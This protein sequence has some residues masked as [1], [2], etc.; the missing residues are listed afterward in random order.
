MATPQLWKISQIS[1]KGFLTHSRGGFLERI[2]TDGRRKSASESFFQQLHVSGSRVFWGSRDQVTSRWS[3]ICWQQNSC[4]KIFCVCFLDLVAAELKKKKPANGNFASL[5][6]FKISF[7]FWGK[8]KHQGNAATKSIVVPNISHRH[9]FTAHHWTG[10]NRTEPDS[11]VSCVIRRINKSL[12]LFIH[13]HRASFLWMG[14]RDVSVF[15]SRVPLW[16]RQSSVWFFSFLKRKKNKQKK[17][18]NKLNLRGQSPKL[19]TRIEFYRCHL[20]EFTPEIQRRGWGAFW[21]G[22]GGGNR[23]ASGP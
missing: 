5:E 21:G 6:F 22:L 16:E 13:F 7:L 17:T 10:P 20:R 3:N 2:H 12:D 11:L 4:S 14:W 18:W 8:K 9:N 23:K 1:Q 15:V 19:A